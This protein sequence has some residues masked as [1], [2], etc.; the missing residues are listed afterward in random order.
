M[1]KVSQVIEH[2]LKVL[3]SQ[4]HIINKEPILLLHDHP[5]WV[6][7]THSLLGYAFYKCELICYLIS[8]PSSISTTSPDGKIIGQLDVDIIPYDIVI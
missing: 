5:L 7:P 1:L 3:R 6:E 4:L 2:N 8:N